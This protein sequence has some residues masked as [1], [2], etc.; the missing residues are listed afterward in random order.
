MITREDL[1][2]RER[3]V[4]YSLRF[5]LEVRVLIRRF[6]RLLSAEWCLPTSWRGALCRLGDPS[7]R[8]GPGLGG[9]GAAAGVPTVSRTRR[10]P[11]RTRAGVMVPG[12]C[13]RCQGSRRSAARAAASAAG[14]RW[15]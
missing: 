2:L 10:N 5:N 14:C 7:G 8:P 15:R 12:G 3:F 1:G 4:H 13:G 11:R 9:L 6:V